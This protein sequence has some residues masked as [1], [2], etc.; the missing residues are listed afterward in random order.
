MAILASII[1]SMVVGKRNASFFRDI[2][3]AAVS[4]VYPACMGGKTREK[5]VKVDAGVILCCLDSYD[6]HGRR[7]CI[8]S[9]RIINTKSKTKNKGFDT[10]STV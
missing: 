1:I 8:F 10:R 4:E 5:P 7:W 9:G 2:E 6:G 3:L